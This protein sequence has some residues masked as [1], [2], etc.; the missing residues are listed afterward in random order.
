[1]IRKQTSWLCVKCS[2]LDK[3]AHVQAINDYF[4]LIA[5]TIT[6]KQARDFLNITS[7]RLAQYLLNSMSLIQSGYGKGTSYSLL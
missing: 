1:M 7:P 5:P 2:N 3:K 4:H 6:N